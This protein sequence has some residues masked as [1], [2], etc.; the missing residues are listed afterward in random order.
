MPHG[1]LVAAL[2]AE[3]LANSGRFSPAEP[4][5][6][7]R[8]A[9]SRIRSWRPHVSRRPIPRPAAPQRDRSVTTAYRRCIEN[10]RRGSAAALLLCRL[11]GL[12]LRRFFGGLFSGPSPLEHVHHR[13]IPLVTGVLEHLIVVVL[14]DGNI[15]GPGSGKRLG[16]VERDPIVDRV[17]VHSSEAFD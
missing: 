4:A 7:K 2:R 14:P 5:R 13:I 1:L 9:N 16:I 10:R 11:L 15:H 8:V 6:S 12:L 3:R 17:G